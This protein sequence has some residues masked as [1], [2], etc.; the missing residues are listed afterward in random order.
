MI[1]YEAFRTCMYQILRNFSRLQ[2]IRRV[3]DYLLFDFEQAMR[4]EC[5]SWLRR[6]SSRLACSRF[7]PAIQL[8]IITICETVADDWK[9]E[10]TSHWKHYQGP[11]SYNKFS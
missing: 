2:D 7:F 10:T 4:Q 11:I 9:L 5:G 3:M 1:I 8:A 6:V